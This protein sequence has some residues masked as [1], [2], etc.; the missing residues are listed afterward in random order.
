MQIR[1]YQEKDYPDLRRLL[2]I[3]QEYERTVEPDRLPG[4]G[5]VDGYLKYLLEENAKNQGKIFFAEQD[6][7]LIGFIAIRKEL[8]DF[9]LIN[10]ENPGLYISDL[11]IDPEYRGKGIGKAL[12][13]KAEEYAKSL[14]LSHLRLGVVAKN[15]ARKFYKKEGFNEYDITMVKELQGSQ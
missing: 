8:K 5:M 10:I 3:L 12:L 4:E 13:K 7:Q 15:P 14:G 9:E 1:E 6:G 2:I 11:I